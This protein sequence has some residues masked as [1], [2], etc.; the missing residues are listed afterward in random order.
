M[1][2][3]VALSIFLCV[4]LV[5]LISRLR[6][7][8]NRLA[9]HLEF[10]AAM[11]EIGTCFRGGEASKASLTSSTQAALRVLQ[12]FFNADQCALALLDVRTGGEAECFAAT[13]P[14][15]IWKNVRLLEIASRAKGEERKPVFDIVSAR[16]VRSVGEGISGLCH[17]LALKA[18]EELVAVCCLVYERDRP[19]PCSSELQ[20]LE[21]ATDR[22]CNYLDLR[23]KETE[24]NLL[25]RQLEHAER[26]K[27]AGTLAGGIAHEFNNI[28]GAIIGYAEM[29]HSLLHRPSRTRGYI[30]QIILAGYRARLII[31]QT[32]ALSRNRARIAKP[33]NLS[34]VV[35]DLAPL[36]RV[37]CPADV[38]LNFKI[39]ERQKVVEG[40]P[41]EIQQILINL[42][43]NASEAFSNEGR[44]EVRVS[45]TVVSQSKTLARCTLPAGDYVLLSVCDDGEGIAESVLPHIFEPFFTTRSRSG[46]TGLG[47]A[48][49][50]GHVGALAGYIDVVSRVGRGTHF[51]IYLPRS[52]KEPVSIDRFFGPCNTPFGNGEIVAVVEPDPTT[53]AAFEDKIAALGYEP[54]GFRTFERLCDWILRG[55]AA[56]LIV[57]DHSS[58]PGRQHAD[59]VRAPLKTVPVIIVGGTNLNMPLAAGDRAST[60]AVPKPV[61]SRVLAHAIRTMIRT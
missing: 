47:L 22:V 46:G 9:R 20:F 50:H 33:F 43:K 55:K 14:G 51:N 29:A 42:C 19:R 1:I 24:R 4:S 5:A 18:S 25:E 38:E 30:G 6:L 56:D 8:T 49:V 39:D 12:R 44:I 52:P 60:L 35:M 26:L 45:H 37:A 17:M 3:L 54:V 59:E 61:S 2:F 27:T 11:K 13:T 48:A 36:L 53:L 15:P 21:S 16:K 32:L 10:E 31:D 41:L 28:L 34:E 7:Q 57:A 40:S 23:R 58:L